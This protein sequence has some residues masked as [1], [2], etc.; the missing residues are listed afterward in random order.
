MN[1]ETKAL[2]R[3]LPSVNHLLAHPTSDRLNTQFGVSNTTDQIRATLDL[4]RQHIL[5]GELAEV[6]GHIEPTYILAQAEEAL[7]ASFAPSL[8][9]VINGTGVIIHTNL[10]RAT[11]SRD[12]QTAVQ[13]VA[14]SYGTL[15][16]NIE[17]GKRGKRDIHIERLVTQVTGAESALVVNNT[18]SAVM[19]ILAAFCQGKEVIISRGQLVE[20]GGGF[21]VPDVMAQSGAKLVEVGTTNRTHLRDYEQAISEN[22]AAIFIAHHSNFR[23][24]GFTSEPSLADICEL[25]H[26]KGV[27]VIY[28]QGSGCML[29]TTPYGLIQEPTVLEGVEAGCDLVAFS[30]DKLLGG[31]QAGLICGSQTWV[32]ALKKHPLAR[33]LRP[34]KLCIAGLAATLTHY[35]KNEVLT[36]IPVWQMISMPLDVIESR[37]KRWQAELSAAGIP[38]EVEVG[39]STVGGGS[40]PGTTIESRVLVLTPT[41]VEQFAGTIRQSSPHIIG[42][43]QDNQLLLDP[44]TVAVEQE[45]ALI[46]AIVTLWPDKS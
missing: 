6:N 19:M 36:E 17:N 3:R 12:A 13:T 45:A 2:L 4:I 15:E 37:A 38:A 43:I 34:D 28:D 32:Q 42:R 1:A 24:I 8:H 30:G 9:G 7:K 23:I 44:R 39:Q 21:R 10:G 41:R 22:T 35:L 26:S 31:P 29:D 18:A 16:F 33:A 25:A 11:L 40:L 5:S 27:P 20:I 14:A 46:K